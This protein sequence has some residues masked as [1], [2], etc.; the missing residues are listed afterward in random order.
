MN[1]SHAPEPAGETPSL[2]AARQSTDG[3]AS[4]PPPPPA[5]PSG[6]PATGDTPAHRWGFGAFLL[7]ELVFLIS[8]VLVVMPFDRTATGRLPPVG[9]LVSVAAPTLLAT[10]VALLA[11]VVRGNGPLKDLK[12]AWNWTDV[13]LGIGIGAIG[14]VV[15]VIA[16]NL[17]S[18]WVGGDN[19]NSAVGSLLDGLELSP[20]LAVLIFLHLWLVAPLCEEIIYRGL[21]WGAMERLRWSRWTAFVLSTAI[22]AAAHLEPDRTPLLLVIAIPIGL[23][24]LLSGRLL[25]SIVVHQLNNLMGALGILLTALG[26]MPM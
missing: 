8:S 11:T 4:A 19:A 3:V 12:L 16:S 17:W 21:L 14:L 20:L 24:R 13:R 25:A 2:G 1:P 6:V 9:V 18:R 10:L 15:T 26:A 5:R 22:F 23:A 7:V